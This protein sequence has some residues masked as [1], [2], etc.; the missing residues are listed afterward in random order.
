MKQI[1]FF[2]VFLLVA[3][4]SCLMTNKV[5]AQSSNNVS[6]SPQ[7][8]NLDL[9]LDLPEAE[10]SY[11]NNTSQTIE[12]SLSMQDVKELEDRGIPGL[13]DQNQS[14]NYK[15][16]LSSWA[17]FSNS[18][19]VIS[20]GETKKVTVFI[21]KERLSIGGHYA[22]VLA[23]IRQRDDEKSLKVRAILSSLLFVRTGSQL[24]IEEALITEFNLSQD[25]LAFPKTSNFRINNTGNVDIIPRGILKIYDP[26]GREIARSIVNEGSLITLPESIRK[27]TIPVNLNKAILPP[28][29]Y[30]ASLTLTYGKK[31]LELTTST[32][33]FSLGSLTVDRIFIIS[34]LGGGLSLLLLKF[35]RSNNSVK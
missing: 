13:L 7:L 26:F 6:V 32:N 16:G 3:I 33:F 19:L 35:R 1:R 11:T 30:K 10:Y 18:N 28:G 4:V 20:P 27:Y 25:Y 31:T 23:E 21:D 12:I 22:A 8:V 5:F 9:S 34:L 2:V 15:Y 17:S 24:E 29:V 14:K